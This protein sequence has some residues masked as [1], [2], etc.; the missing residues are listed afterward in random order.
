MHRVEP[1]AEGSGIPRV[2]AVADGRVRPDR[3]RLLPVK[4]VG[5]LLA[6]SSGMALGREGPSVQMGASAAVIVATV[7]RRNLADLRLL[8][9]AGAAA[10][11]AT[12]FNA[13]IA[14]GVFVLEEL[15]KRFDPRTTVATLVASASGFLAAHLLVESR[16]DF[17]MKPIADPRIVE[18]GW[19]LAIGVVTGLLGVLYNGAVMAA[20]RRADASRVP[21]EARAAATGALVGLLV[22]FAPD[23]VG[24]GDGLTQ[25]GALRPRGTARR[26]R[27]AR[28]AVRAGGGFLRRSNPRR[29]VRAD[30]GPGLAGRPD[31]RARR[32]A[33]DA[34]RRAPACPPAR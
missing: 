8:V 4:Y 12:A 34:A 19:I 11:L 17:A 6:I 30:A 9:A 24:S 29:V 18:S 2:E 14:G 5:G 28:A 3:F 25:A 13:P 21:K 22:W 10:G 20:L 16:Y 1:H 23:L 26:H 33:P 32:R 31:R 27:C 7:T 15:V